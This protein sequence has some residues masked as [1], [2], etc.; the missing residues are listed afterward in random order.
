MYYLLTVSGLT[1]AFSL[2]QEL[3]DVDCSFVI[4]HVDLGAFWIQ[5]FSDG[6]HSVHRTVELSVLY[7]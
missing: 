4:L 1:P 5:T 3:S 2:L 7:R 6:E